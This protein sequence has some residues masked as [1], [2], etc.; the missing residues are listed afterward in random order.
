[1]SR[2]HLSDEE[3]ARSW[4][5]L[6]RAQVQEFK[7]AFDIFD[8][9]GGGTITC[10]ELSDVLRSLGQKPSKERLDAMVGEMDADGD[11]AIDFAEFL[12]MM[13]R[14]MNEGDPEQELRDVFAVF[15]KDQSGTI[16]A[17]EL[18]SVMRIVGEKMTDAEIE[19]AI[20]LA[21]TTGDGEVDYEEFVSFVMS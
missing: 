16:N 2:R 1:M 4:P 19:D 9:D 7:E 13:L 12:T 18:R 21:D 11:G 17:E 14:R 8:V 5:F 3:L 6:T 20:R 15:D 10:E